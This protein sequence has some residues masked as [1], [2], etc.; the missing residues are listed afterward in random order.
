M[1]LV[2]V[3]KQLLGKGALL[4]LEGLQRD[5]QQGTLEST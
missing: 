2:V 5:P 1:A 4:C 3:R